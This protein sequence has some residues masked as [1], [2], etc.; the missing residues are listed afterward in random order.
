MATVNIENALAGAA[1]PTGAKNKN[2]KF[3]EDIISQR[4]GNVKGEI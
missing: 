4:E 3:S 1:T 2:M